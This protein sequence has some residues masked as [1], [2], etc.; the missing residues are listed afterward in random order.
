[1][2]GELFVGSLEGTTWG[3]EGTGEKRGK[4]F[5]FVMGAQLE[6]GD[7]ETFTGGGGG[8]GL[9]EKKGGGEGRGVDRLSMKR[10]P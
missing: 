3:N 1:V 6:I 10:G 8:G 4:I 5:N 7:T 2:F 9:G